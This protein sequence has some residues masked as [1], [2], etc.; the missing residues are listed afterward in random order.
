M[1]RALEVFRSTDARFQTARTELS[2]GEL[3][4]A[5]GDTERAAAYLRSAH[6]AFVALRVPRH[7]RLVERLAGNLR[8]ALGAV[9]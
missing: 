7:V 8:V 2:L 5:C 1:A 6:A 4:H 9:P 3:T